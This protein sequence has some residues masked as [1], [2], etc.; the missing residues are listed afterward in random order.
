MLATLDSCFVVVERYGLNPYKL[1]AAFFRS[2]QHVRGTK[3]A[4]SPT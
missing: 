2:H 4:L 3:Q 1:A